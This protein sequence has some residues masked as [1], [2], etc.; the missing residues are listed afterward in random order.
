MFNM[1]THLRFNIMANVMLTG[2]RLAQ[3]LGKISDYDISWV[4]MNKLLG[5]RSSPF[6]DCFESVYAYPDTRLHCR[7]TQYLYLPYGI[8]KV[9]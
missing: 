9:V 4:V 8:M 2:S 1:A 5:S 3:I 7:A 6:K